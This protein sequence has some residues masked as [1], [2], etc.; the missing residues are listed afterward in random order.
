[1]PSETSKSERIEPAVVGP[2]KEI[3]MTIKTANPDIRALIETQVVLPDYLAD[4][5]VQRRL[6]KLLAQFCEARVKNSQ[7]PTM[8]DG[9]P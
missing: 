8:L 6:G 1:M 9:S 2:V 4:P 7:A 5:L 3:V